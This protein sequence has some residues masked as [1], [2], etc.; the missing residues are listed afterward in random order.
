MSFEDVVFVDAMDDPVLHR[1]K[2]Y[3]GKK[4]HEVA[5]LIEGKTLL[6]ECDKKIIF[7]VDYDDKVIELLRKMNYSSYVKSFRKL[8]QEFL[9]MEAPPPLPKFRVKDLKFLRDAQRHF[10]KDVKYPLIKHVFYNEEENKTLQID[11]S[12][13]NILDDSFFLSFQGSV[14]GQESRYFNYHQL[15]KEKVKD[16]MYAYDFCSLKRDLKKYTGKMLD[17]FLEWGAVMNDLFREEIPAGLDADDEKNVR[18]KIES[19]GEKKL[20]VVLF[21]PN[22][23][24][25]VELGNN[26]EKKFDRRTL[27]AMWETVFALK[28]GEP[29][30]F[31]SVPNSVWNG[32]SI[33]TSDGK[34]DLFCGTIKSASGELFNVREEMEIDK[35]IVLRIF[36]SSLKNKNVV[37]AFSE[38]LKISP[39]DFLHYMLI[40]QIEPIISKK[41]RL[42]I[43][44][45]GLIFKSI[46]ACL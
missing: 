35:S 38:V 13:A 45:L 7:A 44:A 27:N 39:R 8:I 22:M 18:F 24:L 30:E 33:M 20:L 2:I 23:L 25:T 21:R 6:L 3:V 16:F 17:V 4:Q 14:Q 29:L 5:L 42:M 36:I 9:T 28:V 26:G 41:I 32:Y 15:R 19:Y 12:V 31:D 46:D 1:E 43:A 11:I 40:E 10:D 37:F 34:T